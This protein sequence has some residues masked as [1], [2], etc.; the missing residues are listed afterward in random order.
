LFLQLKQVECD[1]RQWQRLLIL[2]DHH[3]FT[4][5]QGCSYYLLLQ[6]FHCL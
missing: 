3:F 1:G 2:S 4:E 5:L 6:S